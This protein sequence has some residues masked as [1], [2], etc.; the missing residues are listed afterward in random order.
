MDIPLLVLVQHFGVVRV[1]LRCVAHEQLVYPVRLRAG[2]EVAPALAIGS[3]LR[4][5]VS[6]APADKNS[7]SRIE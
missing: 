6:P 3:R 2:D 1:D 7:L 4:R 5:E